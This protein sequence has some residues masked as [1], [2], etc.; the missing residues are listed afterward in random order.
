MPGS[1]AH[2]MTPVH[3]PKPPDCHAPSL[4][5]LVLQRR[6]I[7]H[8][9]S[10]TATSERVSGSG[11]DVPLPVM[12][13][14]SVRTSNPCVV[15]TESVLS[16]PSSRLEKSTSKMYC[17]FGNKVPAGT[18]DMVIVDGKNSCEYTAENVIAS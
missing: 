7:L 11:T 16:S 9:S 17:V 12:T 18:V 5:A 10:V 6:K 4:C 15:A 2:M 14:A 1:G 13:V 3:H 8:P